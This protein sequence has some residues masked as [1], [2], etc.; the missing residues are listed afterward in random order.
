MFMSRCLQQAAPVSMDLIY[1]VHDK[2]QGQAFVNMVI[3]LGIP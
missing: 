2:G 1:L 3:N